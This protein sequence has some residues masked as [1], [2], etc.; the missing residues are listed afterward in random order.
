VRTGVPAT[1]LP[2]VRLGGVAPVRG[3]RGLRGRTAAAVGITIDDLAFALSPAFLAYSGGGMRGGSFAVL[4]G[5]VLIRR[6]EAIRGVRI[7]GAARDG[8]LRLRVGGPAAAHG[9]VTFTAGGRLRGRLGGRRISVRLPAIATGATA[10]V[11]ATGAARVFGAPFV[12]KKSPPRLV[13]SPVR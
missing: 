11:A 13:P 5:R 2:P 7:S 1:R 8:T 9:R 3:M 6:Y 4:E 10:S 12:T